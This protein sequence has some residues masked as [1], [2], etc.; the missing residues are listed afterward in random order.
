MVYSEG[1]K[2]QKGK[3]MK[4]RTS[5]PPIDQMIEEVAEATGIKA[6]T[7]AL[8]EKYGDTESLGF[9]SDWTKAMLAHKLGE[10]EKLMKGDK[11]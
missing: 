3:K 10:N 1:S 5:E 8:V 11:Q 6:E 4:K 7:D 2:K 9:M